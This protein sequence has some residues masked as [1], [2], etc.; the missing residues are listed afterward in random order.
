MR[1]PNLAVVPAWQRTDA[2]AHR[3][4][5]PESQALVPLQQPGVSARNRNSQWG[6][7]PD[8]EQWIEEWE[9]RAAAAAVKD[10]ENSGV[11]QDLEALRAGWSTSQRPGWQPGLGASRM[12]QRGDVAARRLSNVENL[13]RIAEGEASPREVSE[14]SVPGGLCLAEAP[15]SRMTPQ[16]ACRTEA[17]RWQQASP[18]S[19]AVDRKPAGRRPSPHRVTSPLKA[20]VQEGDPWS[21]WERRWAETFEQMGLNSRKPARPHPSGRATQNESDADKTPGGRNGAP[22]SDA[23]KAWAGSSARCPRSSR[24][25]GETPGSNGYSSSRPPPQTGSFR[26]ETPPRASGSEQSSGSGRG[27]GWGKAPPRRPTQSEPTKPPM[28]RQQPGPRFASFSAYEEAWTKFEKSGMGDTSELSLQD[29][30]W[31]LDLKTVSGIESGDSSADCKRKLRAAL[32]RWHP[33]KWGSILGRIRESDK[34]EVTDRVQ[35][36]TRRIL[37]EKAQHA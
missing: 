10:L 31:P 25:S 14:S 5:N 35:E 33:D 18:K 29:I 13:R 1:D 32:L 30:P 2:I 12:N 3:R 20:M 23:S 26:A 19:A 6:S 11:D 16:R 28:S 9:R 22:R 8:P 7:A 34:D 36:V 17:T 24:Q 21:A 15:G 37:E 27:S 4:P